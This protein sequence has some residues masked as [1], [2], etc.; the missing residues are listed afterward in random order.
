VIRHE[1]YSETADVYS[2][3]VVLWQLVT[4]DDPFQD[5]SQIEAAAAVAMDNER[6]PFPDNTPAALEKL[7]KTCWN[8]DPDK[9]LSF[10]AITAELQ[11]IEKELSEEEETWIAEPLG[12]TVYRK[13]ITLADLE[14][15]P[16][17][18]KQSEKKKGKG[19]RTL[20]NRKSTHF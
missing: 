16:Q 3:A 18:A 7:I 19:F 10:E 6:P 11:T 4:R 17:G 12:H 8:Q 20:F 15:P 9:R 14:I 13:K 5:K 2:F 1:N